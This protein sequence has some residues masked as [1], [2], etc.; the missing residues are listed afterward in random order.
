[1][2]F[3]NY[4]NKNKNLFISNIIKLLVK[5]GIKDEN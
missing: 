4:K 3:I 5:K 1:M 2:F